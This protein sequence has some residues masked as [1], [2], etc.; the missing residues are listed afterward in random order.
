MPVLPQ[1]V[2]HS[3]AVVLRAWPSGETSVVASLLTEA[4]GYVR[5]I[6]KGARQGL[7]RLQ[8][9]VYSGFAAAIWRCYHRRRRGTR[10]RFFTPSRP[11]CWNCRGSRP[12]CR[13]AP[14]AAA[15]WR[16]RAAV[17]V[18][19]P[20]APSARRAPTRPND[21]SRP[22][23]WRPC[24]RWAARRRSG[25]SRRT[26][27]ETGILLHRFLTYHL[28]EYRLPAGLELLRAARSA[29]AA[30]AAAKDDEPC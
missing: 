2:V 20:A 22:R 25:P 27:R 23:R 17:S 21:R 26:S 3:R 29:D 24:G 8:P 18:R 7:S 5:V 30:A 14:P 19:P 12:S 13:P 4:R 16:R 11:R 9:L 10:P 6:A 15:A 28:P 1:P